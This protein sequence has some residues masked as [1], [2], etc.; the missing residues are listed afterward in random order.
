MVSVDGIDPLPDKLEAIR[1]WP[2]PH[3]LRDVRAFFGLASYYRRFVKGFATIAEPLTRL[4]RKMARFEWTEEAQQAIEALKK[5]LV[6]AFPL[7]QE[8]CILDTAVLSQKIDG[9]ERPIAFFS[10]VMNST[11]RNYCTTRRELLV[12]ISALQHFRHYLLGNKVI[13][14]TDHHSLKWLQ[15]FKRP[16]GILAR[17]VETLAEFHF[18]IEHRPSR[19]HSNVDDVSRPFC[20]QCS[21]KVTKVRWVDELERADELT[22]PLT[23]NPEISPEE[24]REF[25]A[26]D[27]DLGPLVE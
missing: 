11:Q 10:R 6:E 4:T 5:A 3:C 7:F 16:E 22:E 21:D 18:T 23:L 27:P 13:L 9:V 25:Q 1:D 15:T 14:R 24:V 12:V 17:W 8:P 2:V 20:K 26:E 19:L